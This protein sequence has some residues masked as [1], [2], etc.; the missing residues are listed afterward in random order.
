M[1]RRRE[2]P[3]EVKQNRRKI[4][5]AGLAA[6]SKA[7]KA[8]NEEAA[9]RELDVLKALDL[10]EED[11][12]GKLRPGPD[13]AEL[14]LPGA[15]DEGPEPSPGSDLGT[16]QGDRGRQHRTTG[17]GQ[18]RAVMG[19]GLG[20]VLPWMNEDGQLVDDPH[21]CRILFRWHGNDRRTH[22]KHVTAH[23]MTGSIWKPRTSCAPG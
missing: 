6:Y 5:D 14:P 3:E 15:G 7:A 8:G 23:Q 12:F 20:Y 21:S 2:V 9:A 17:R 18:G 4:L 10:V 1:S 13:V 16:A 19:W 11:D 22:G